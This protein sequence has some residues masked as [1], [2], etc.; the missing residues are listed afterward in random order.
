MLLLRD[1]TARTAASGR[2]KRRVK[3]RQLQQLTCEVVG[4]GRDVHR[5]LG[6][7]AEESFH[8]IEKPWRKTRSGVCKVKDRSE[9]RRG[10]GWWILKGGLDP[11]QNG[12]IPNSVLGAK[13][14]LFSRSPAAWI[15]TVVILG[16]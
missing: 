15:Q 11:G 6:G 2:G 3:A 13:S 9:R 14:A 16:Q 5:R 4:I 8:F 7:F 1:Q 10:V 12:R